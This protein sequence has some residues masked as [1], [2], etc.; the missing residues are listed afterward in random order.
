MGW[1]YMVFF[2]QQMLKME[3]FQ[4]HSRTMLTKDSGKNVSAEDI[5]RNFDEKTDEEKTN[6][7]ASNNMSSD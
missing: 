5:K 2:Q 1:Q 7:S 4:K 6:T 3:I